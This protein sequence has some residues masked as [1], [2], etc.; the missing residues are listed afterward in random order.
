MTDNNQVDPSI[1]LLVE[2]IGE[3][4]VEEFVAPEPGTETG[5]TT[6]H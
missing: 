5:F 2:V 3:T 1:E 6:G 4:P